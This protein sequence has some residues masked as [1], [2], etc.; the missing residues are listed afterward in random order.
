MHYSI[1]DAETQEVLIDFDEYSR[2][3]NDKSGHF[4]ILDFS[5]LHVGRYYK[6]YISCS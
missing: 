2:I 3:S 4:F 5:S 6:F 1:R